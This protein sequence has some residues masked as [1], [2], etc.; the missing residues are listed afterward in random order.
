MN[1]VDKTQSYAFV[2]RFTTGTGSG[3]IAFEQKAAE[4]KTV[5]TQYLSMVILE[6]SELDSSDYFYANDT[7]AASHTGSFVDRATLTV[8]SPTS[9]DTYLMFAWV[10]TDT[11]KVANNSEMQLEKT[12]GSTTTT[13]LISYEG[14]DLTEV[15]SWWV[16][17]PYTMTDDSTTW[18]IQTRDDDASGLVNEYLESTIFGLRLNAFENFNSSY[19]DI[20]TVTTSTTWVELKSLSITPDTTGD[21]VAVG[22]SVFRPQSTNRRSYQ[23]ITVAGASKPNTAPESEFNASSNDGTDLLG[24]PQLTTFSGTASSA[25]TVDLDVKKTASANIGWK[26]YA[27]SLFTTE[28]KSTPAPINYSA[29]A[30]Q[31]FASGDVASQSYNSGDVASETF[32]SGDVASEVNPS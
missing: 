28:I 3:G 5:R 20:E 15:L 17:R 30:T 1:A 4:T 26:Q 25:S 18:T 19:T 2:G 24:M 16:T 9:D 7:T 27:L 8:S 13:P 11:N 29:V 23:R 10:A 6:L 22:S 12:G 31:T 21:I 32:S 14:E